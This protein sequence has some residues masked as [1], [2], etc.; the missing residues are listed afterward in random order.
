M[1]E[2]IG[3]AKAQTLPIFAFNT[4]HNLQITVISLLKLAIGILGLVAVIFLIY[5]GIMYITAG[6]NPESATKARTI[7]INAIIGIVIILLAF[8]VVWWV[9]SIIPTT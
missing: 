7:I 1:F 6:G 4:G 8:T 5:G 2:L 9:S 3:K